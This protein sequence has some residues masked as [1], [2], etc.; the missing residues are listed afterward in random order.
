MNYLELLKIT[1]QIYKS[2][3]CFG[4]DPVISTLHKKFISGG[5][6]GF[7]DMLEELFD[8]MA[9]QKVA[10]GAFKPNLGF[11]SKHGKAKD[12]NFE[13]LIVLAKIFDLIE[14]YFPG[15]ITILDFKKADILK[16]SENYMLEGFEFWDADAV[17]IPPY[18]GSDSML[19]FCNV[20]D[21]ASENRGVYVLNLTSNEGKNDFEMLG[22][23]DGSLVYMR[24]ADWIRKN[25]KNH[26]GLG[27][28]V[29]A[30]WLTQLEQIAY[31]YT[32]GGVEI[33]L[34][35]PGIGKKSVGGQGGDA[36]EVYEALK[37]A[38]YDVNLARLNLSSGLTHPWGEK[39][40]A[41][42]D[43]KEI[44]TDNLFEYNRITGMA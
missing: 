30:T 41:P 43:W 40:P 22:T 39:Q 33:P 10:P 19:P 29:G 11:Y 21:K 28:V 42:D 37:N 34:L 36:K 16:S 24:V 7:Y 31:D 2:I 35:I 15:M 32:Q 8:Y 23:T 3:I 4:L 25:A 12:L 20:P 18:M 6:K 17:T 14:L 1:T 27:A 5:I 44:I 38:G 9:S 13:G 26:I